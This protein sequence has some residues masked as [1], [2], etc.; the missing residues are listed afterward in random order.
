MRAKSIILAFILYVSFNPTPAKSHCYQH[1]YYPYP[2]HCSSGR[3]ETGRRTRLKISEPLAVRVR[4][5]P[6]VPIPDFVMPDMSAAWETPG[7][8]KELWDGIN[9]K[10]AIMQMENQHSRSE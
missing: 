9:R 1:W 2:Q 4:V 6:S 3:G 7:I 8:T 5:P 10:R